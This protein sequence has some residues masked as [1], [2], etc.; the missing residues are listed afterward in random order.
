M[1]ETKRI[2]IDRPEPGDLSQYNFNS[3]ET[4]FDYENSTSLPLPNDKFQGKD[5]FTKVVGHPV[6]EGIIERN[7]KFAGDPSI[8]I[9]NLYIGNTGV[10]GTVKNVRVAV[11]MFSEKAYGADPTGDGYTTLKN[12]LWDNDDDW[13][14]YDKSFG[15]QSEGSDIGNLE[16]LEGV[17]IVSNFGKDS[18][19]IS[20]GDIPGR[21]LSIDEDLDDDIYI[22]SGI[23]AFE[24]SDI[25]DVGT[26]NDELLTSLFNQQ[27]NNPIYIVVYMKGDKKVAWP[28][29][30][31]SRKRK[32]SVFKISNE[33]L[34]QKT[35]DSF[36]GANYTVNFNSSTRTRTGEGGGGATQAAWKVSSLTVSFN[37]S[38]GIGNNFSD[39][40]SYSQFIPEVLPPVSVNE[41]IFNSFD[42]LGLLNPKS[43]LDNDQPAGG[44]SN[45]EIPIGRQT[46]D[47]HP[48]YFPFTTFG[49]KSLNQNILDINSSDLQTYHQ[50]FN[51]IM[52][53]SAPLNVTFNLDIKDIN[54][55]PFI[56]YD[57]G[58][59]REYYYFVIDWDDTENKFKTIDDFLISKP[60]NEFDYLELQN[61]NLY[62]VKKVGGM[63][64]NTDP[65]YLATLPFP[66]YRE[67][68]NISATQDGSYLNF[69]FFRTEYGQ[70]HFNDI[71]V[72]AQAGRPDISQYLVDL[73]IQDVMYDND[74]GFPFFRDY[75]PDT[76]LQ[77]PS[78]QDAGVTPQSPTDFLNPSSVYTPSSITETLNNVYTT[79]GIKNLK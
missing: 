76:E 5:L 71:S 8:K 73:N 11:F 25:L 40:S 56:P 38:P 26:N 21:K 47:R 64:F 58:G 51:S 79:P 68:F 18:T 66:Q 54:N 20:V 33:D 49:Y 53:S 24:L 27:Q 3:N 23:K 13:L 10:G 29:K 2:L 77:I 57:F 45:A 65:N 17:E 31:D 7:L 48:D 32:Y 75:E 19:E 52:K 69:G 70:L 12:N 44:G 1:A 14:I 30:T 46:N 72:W 67:E 4:N 42:W 16:E 55:N 59:E 74:F 62:K 15:N 22:P 34:F 9:D 41:N 36:S 60:E 35:G 63:N 28:I 78:A 6:N 39:V 50:D 43:Q 37:T 61:Q